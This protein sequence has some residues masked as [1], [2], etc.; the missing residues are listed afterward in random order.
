LV[1]YACEDQREHQQ[2]P[3][4]YTSYL[5]SGHLWATVF[6]NWESEF[7][8][9]AAYVL[10]TVFLFQRG[11]AESKDP[12]TAEE[13]DDDPALINTTP[14]HRDQ[15]GGA[16]LRSRSIN[17]PSLSRSFSSSFSLL[18]DTPSAGQPITTYNNEQRE[19]SQPSASV[20]QYVGTSRF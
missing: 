11:S 6:E 4:R 13:V 19:H 8:Q 7:L 3:I 17:I 16:G 1:R 5:A 14:T 15:S 20:F 2:R 12:D 9:M 18:S 10:F